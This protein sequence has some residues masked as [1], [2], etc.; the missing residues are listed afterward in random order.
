MSFVASRFKLGT[1]A[2]AA[3]E[4]DGEDLPQ[5]LQAPAPKAA[6][7]PSQQRKCRLAAKLDGFIRNTIH[8]NII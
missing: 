7:Q 4:G 3:E 8:I 1:R 5:Q 2:A 6:A